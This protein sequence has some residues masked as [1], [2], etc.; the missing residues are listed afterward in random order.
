M[1]DYQMMIL[2]E[3]QRLKVKNKMAAEGTQEGRAHSSVTNRLALL[4]KMKEFRKL[5][6][7]PK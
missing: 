1:V 4:S 3:K 7:D 2:Q 5:T 6:S